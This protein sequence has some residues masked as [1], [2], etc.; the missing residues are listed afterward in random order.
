MDELQLIAGC[1]RGESWARKKL[2]ELHAPAMMSVCM[3]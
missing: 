2:Y 1:K 3:R